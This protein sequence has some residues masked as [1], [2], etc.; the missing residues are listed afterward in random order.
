MR[1]TPPNASAMPRPTQLV[2]RSSRKTA[3]SPA[4]ST[5]AVWISST[6]VPAST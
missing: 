3:A 1:A 2:N 4:I 5:G 6:A